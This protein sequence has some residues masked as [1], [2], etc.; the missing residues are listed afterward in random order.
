MKSERFF[1]KALTLILPT[2]IDSELQDRLAKITLL[3]QLRRS[4]PA[5]QPA[6]QHIQ[7]LQ[8]RAGLNPTVTKVRLIDKSRRRLS[9]TLFVIGLNTHLFPA[10]PHILFSLPTTTTTTFSPS[11]PN[12]HLPNNQQLKIELRLV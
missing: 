7:T 6:S 3:G 8:N 9:L 5:S 2:K 4:Q 10:P 12:N 11:S 1:Y